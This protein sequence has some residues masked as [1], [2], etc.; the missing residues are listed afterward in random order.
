MAR[1][2]TRLEIE[3]MR[4]SKRRILS[5]TGAK[6]KRITHRTFVVTLARPLHNYTEQIPSCEFPT[7][8][9]PA[10]SLANYCA[11]N[12][13][14]GVCAREHSSP[15]PI[16]FPSLSFADKAFDWPA[17]ISMRNSASGAECAQLC[18]S[19]ANLTSFVPIS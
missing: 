17:K 12:S 13:S 15:L 1:R 5:V 19:R 18:Y 9:Y 4:N 2:Q 7:S 16:E 3:R 14:R 10:V 6:R 8:F 11:G